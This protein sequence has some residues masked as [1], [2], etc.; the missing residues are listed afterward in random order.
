MIRNGE[1]IVAQEV[2]NFHCVGTPIQLKSYCNRY[3]ETAEP[4]RICFDLDN[5]LVTYPDVPGDYSTVRPISRN[6]E[7]LKLLN[8]L[9]HHIIIYTARRMRTHK[10]NVGAILADIGEV[11]ISTL[12]KF[13]IPYDELF[14]GKPYANHCMI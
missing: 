7:F 6:I 14:F 3:I 2:S 5:T 8:R 13:E 10:G 1:T 4:I 9:G 12:N 11:T